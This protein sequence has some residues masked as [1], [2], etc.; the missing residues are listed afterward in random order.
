MVCFA[1]CFSLFV[2]LLPASS[3]THFHLMAVVTPGPWR[4]GPQTTPSLVGLL[5]WWWWWCRRVDVPCV[6]VAVGVLMFTA[7]VH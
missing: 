4:L 5:W 3:A 7:R 2:L 6:F 1:C